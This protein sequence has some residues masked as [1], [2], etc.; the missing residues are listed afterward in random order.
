MLSLILCIHTLKHPPVFQCLSK[1]CCH[2]TLCQL[3]GTYHSMLCTTCCWHMWWLIYKKILTLDFC[4]CF[5]FII[6]L[7]IST[8]TGDYSLP[9]SLLIILHVFIWPKRF[10]TSVEK[11]TN[12]NFPQRQ[13]KSL[14][15]SVCQTNT[16]NLSR[17]SILNDTK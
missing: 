17:H 8:A 5:P 12:H 13:I 7:F 3:Q 4:V 11:N 1:C 9:L 2:F 10:K 14:N 6:E 15:S 16:P